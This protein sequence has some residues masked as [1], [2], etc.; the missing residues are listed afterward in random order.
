[1]SAK[2]HSDRTPSL[3]Y[4]HKKND[5]YTLLLLNQQ[6]L[7]F[8]LVRLCVCVSF[9]DNNSCNVLCFNTRQICDEKR[10]RLTQKNS[11]RLMV[12]IMKIPTIHCATEWKLSLN[13]K[14]TQIVRKEQI[15]IQVNGKDRAE[16]V[17][18]QQKKNAMKQ[19][20]LINGVYYECAAEFNLLPIRGSASNACRNNRQFSQFGWAITQLRIRASQKVHSQTSQLQQNVMK[21]KLRRKFAFISCGF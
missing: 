17:E 2:R 16:S 18:K 10:D 1:M 4:T 11:S 5:L 12:G 14:L 7:W 13:C 8:K 3:Q 15:F 6:F 19:R 20:G 21:I 9:S